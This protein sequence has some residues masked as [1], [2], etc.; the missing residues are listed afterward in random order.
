MRIAIFTET[1][2]P[3][4][5]GIVSI[6]CLALQRLQERGHQALL[7]GRR[8]ELACQKLGLNA[9]KAPLTTSHFSPPRPA[10]D[11]LSLF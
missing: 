5:D 1:F 9:E 11:Q 6:L 3:K 4:L 2:L 10:S 8:F 7:I